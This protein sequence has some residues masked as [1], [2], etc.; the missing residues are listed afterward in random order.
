MGQCLRLWSV[1]KNSTCSQR[2]A[3]PWPGPT[4]KMCRAT[5]PKEQELGSPARSRQQRANTANP[6]PSAALEHPKAAISRLG[7]PPQG[8]A[9]PLM[10]TQG[11]HFTR[12]SCPHGYH[13]HQRIKPAP[14][15][16]QR[17]EE[18]PR[19]ALSIQT[20]PAR[21][22][23]QGCHRHQ[24]IQP[25]PAPAPAL[26]QND[27]E[28]TPG[29]YTFGPFSPPAPVP[30]WLPS[31]PAYQ[32]SPSQRAAAERPGEDPRESYRYPFGPTGQPTCGPMVATGRSSGS[33]TRRR[34]RCS[35][36]YTSLA[37]LPPASACRA[38]ASGRA[39][40]R[41]AHSCPALSTMHVSAVLT[42]RCWPS[43]DA[44]SL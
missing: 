37:G 42:W 11:P 27:R 23:P 16:V 9:G 22:C 26:P 38:G 32:A 30:P 14:A 40:R 33:F 8:L 31:A 29:T 35:P 20:W 25:A 7:G 1:H 12:S 43:A 19:G 4:Q 34:T 21:L 17:P 44:G 5:K 15:P 39:A 3:G 41:E 2:R 28:R 6:G 18:N 13:M 10:V 24:R 36:P